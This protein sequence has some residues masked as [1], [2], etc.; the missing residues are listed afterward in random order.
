MLTHQT[1]QTLRE[2]HLTGMA[3]A[4]HAH[5]QNPELQGL[6]FDERFGMLVDQEWSTRQ[7]RRLARRLQ[8]AKLPLAASVEDL[9]YTCPAD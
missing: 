3:D 5:L 8:E 6:S 1:L 9:D 2:L 4:Y 7:S